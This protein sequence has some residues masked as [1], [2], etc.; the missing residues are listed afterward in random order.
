MYKIDL[1]VTQ[2][3][4]N[5]PTFLI[6][7]AFSVA[8][9]LQPNI[10]YDLFINKNSASGTEIKCYQTKER[11]ES[12]RRRIGDDGA[13]PSEQKELPN[14]NRVPKI[15]QD[16]LAN[17]AGKQNDQNQQENEGNSPTIETLNLLD[18]FVGED[19]QKPAE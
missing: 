5:Q 2:S 12:K 11:T 19:Q 18:T 4:V 14:E 17:F 13:G 7:N 6:K 3:T 10:N 9:F 1:N 16:L 15:T 8:I